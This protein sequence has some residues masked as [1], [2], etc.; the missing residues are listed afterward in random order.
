MYLCG[1][2]YKVKGRLGE[3]GFGNVY[4]AEDTLLK[5][6]WAIKETKLNDDVSYA[7]LKAEISVLSRV[8]HPGI[9]RITDVFR[10]NGHIYIVMDHVKG[11]NLKE[12]LQKKKKIPEKLLFGWCTEICDAVSYLHHMDP[13]VILR[14]LK[15]QNIMVRPDGHMVLIDFGAALRSGADAGFSFASRKYAS[16][17]QLDGKE[18]DIKSD[19]YALG[20][21]IDDVTGKNKP[22]GAKA[23]IKRAT[24]QN[25]R[26]RYKS[27][28]SMRR[29]IILCRHAGKIILFAIT[30]IICGLFIISKAKQ[31]TEEVNEIAAKEQ[32]A[33]RSYEQGLLCFYELNDYKACENYLKDV[34]KE[35]YPE[36]DYYIE[37]SEI[38][39]DRKTDPSSLSKVLAT[40]EEYNE[41][42]VKKEDM[43]RYVKNNFCMA[44]AYLT[45]AEEINGYE[46]AYLLIS[47]V[48]Q[49]IRAEQGLESYEEDAL[50]LMINI[51]ILEGRT[52]AADKDQKYHQA[53]K[54]IEELICLP[55]I[56]SD[57]S[58]TIAKLMDEASLYSE[59]EEYDNAL[60][61]YEKAEKDFPYDPG[62]N[63]FAHL[64]LLMQQGADYSEVMNLWDMTEK[65]EGIRDNPDFN[66]MKDRINGYHSTTDTFTM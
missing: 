49:S 13:P 36:T 23:V 14:D 38:L 50:K 52:S 12:I 42:T 51:S 33:L 6:T 39:S 4:L 26:F 58:C 5:S 10:S 60:K 15:P 11:M 41:N 47:R 45:A 66:V 59:L 18:A 35:E 29:D 48:T 64:S 31:S 2:R 3:G 30:L 46:K 32:T 28:K 55:E 63:Y 17:E 54:H 65:V 44:K 1:T 53:I 40:F 25:P 37:L 43:D 24:M 34:P 27:V 9:V 7:A 20:R 16:P 22:F 62:I 56:S 21:V 19:I 8:S 61:I 57:R